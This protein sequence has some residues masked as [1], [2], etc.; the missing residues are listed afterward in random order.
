MVK[1]R[2]S[3]EIIGDQFSPT[4]FASISHVLLKN[5]HDP[6]EIGKEGRFKGKPIPYG[7]ASIAVSEIAE[8]DWARFDDL[9]SVLETCGSA[10]WQAGADDVTLRC[11]LFHDGQCNFEFSRKQLARIA[12]LKV[13][14][15]ISSYCEEK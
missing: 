8:E 10:L 14:L 15:A 5:A 12:A 1:I 11:S 9:I 2:A 3:C 7:S 13:D 4:I 6:G